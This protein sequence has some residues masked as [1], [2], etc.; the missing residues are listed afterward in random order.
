MTEL[1]S[2]LEEK[3]ARDQMIRD[4][5]EE[6]KRGLREEELAE[7][8]AETAKEAARANKAKMEKMIGKKETWRLRR[9][10]EDVGEEV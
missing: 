7:E 9:I 2:S 1:L 6:L 4:E 5:L 8:E 3:F 10:E